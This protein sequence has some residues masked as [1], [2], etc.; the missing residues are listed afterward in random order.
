MDAAGSVPPR[1]RLEITREA[2]ALRIGYR[3]PR[4]PVVAL[5]LAVW[6]SL[7]VRG[8]VE[9]GRFVLGDEQPIGAKIFLTFWL[10]GWL[11]GAGFVAWALLA[12]AAGREELSLDSRT[13]RIRTSALGLGWTRAFPLEAIEG[14]EPMATRAAPFQFV[15]SGGR[16]LRGGSI[17]FRHGGKTVRFG[18]GLAA[19]DVERIVGELGSRLPARAKGGW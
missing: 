14:L 2:G 19:E 3:T 13:L 16:T 9:A 7:W 4:Q 1:S 15:L 8:G 12:T 11:A 6:L 17:Q 10:A 5:F 18:R